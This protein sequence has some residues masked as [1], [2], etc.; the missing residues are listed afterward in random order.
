[1]VKSLIIICSV[2]LVSLIMASPGLKRTGKVQVKETDRVPADSFAYPDN[3]NPETESDWVSLLEKQFALIEKDLNGNLGVYVKHL[4][5][6][7]S[8]SY[9][10]DDNRYLASTIKIPLAV[11]VLQKVE[12][13]E[14]S[15]QDELVLWE[16][17]FVDGAGDLL[18]QMPGTKYTIL[19]LME[20]MIQNSDNCATDML[21][22]LVG[23]EEL[24]EMVRQSMVSEGLNHI[25]S[26]LQVRHDAFSE[27]HENAAKLTNMDILYVNST[28]SH[29]ER[30]NRLVS[31]LAVDENDLKTGTI[32]DA[33]EQ[34][35][36]RRL[37]SGNLRS[38][39]LL[40]ERLYTGELL[41][42]GHTRLLLDIMEGVTTG[43]RRIKAGLTG[44]FSFAH[45]TGTQI[46]RTVNVGIIYP[47]G[48]ATGFPIIV[49]ASVEKTDDLTEAERALEAVGRSLSRILIG[50][51]GS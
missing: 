15:L 33:F 1:M 30:L 28:R 41:S 50:G 32:S 42:A 29:I 6:N 39:G 21:F 25:T 49:A 8:L 26:I 37:N 24:N 2:I 47:A 23:E 44:D 36:E 12:A 17:D 9:R 43:E 35:Y 5:D 31:R 18:W 13:G 51:D 38:M 46:R 22:R 11:A 27:F 20:R 48:S 4:G 16:S 3:S 7:R 14:I 19:S 34:Y 10:A 40:L 45:K